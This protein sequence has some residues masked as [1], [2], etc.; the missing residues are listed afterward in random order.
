[1]KIVE[2]LT[3]REACQRLNIEAGDLPKATPRPVESFTPREAAPAINPVWREKA[4]KL[5]AYAHT[6]LLLN[7]VQLAWLAGRG[8]NHDAVVRH[9]LGWLN[10]DHYRERTA[11]GLAPETKDNGKLKKL[12]LPAGLVIP[13]FCDAGTVQRL[14]I[15]RPQEDPRYFVVPGSSTT[16]WYSRSR[17]SAP[18]AAVVVESELDAITCACAVDDM[19]VIALGNSSARPDVEAHRLLETAPL[20]LACHDYDEAGKHGSDNLHKWYPGKVK[21]WPVPDGKDPG[22]YSG[23]GGDIKSWLQSATSG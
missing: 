14:R 18:T 23:A 21:R 22:D 15:R 1:L 11:W 10:E 20:I 12:W 9:H 7:D 8:I 3:F 2:G 16:T 4:E 19:H 5:T 13:F 17:S 6:A